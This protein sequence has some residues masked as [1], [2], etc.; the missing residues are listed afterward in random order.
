MHACSLFQPIQQKCRT[1]ARTIR[2]LTHLATAIGTYLALALTTEELTNVFTF[3]GLNAWTDDT[4]AVAARIK[5]ATD[6]FI[7][8]FSIVLK[9]EGTLRQA[10]SLAERHYIQ[11]IYSHGTGLQRHLLHRRGLSV[12]DGSPPQRPVGRMMT[13]LAW[14]LHHVRVFHW[15]Q[16]Q[17]SAYI[18]NVR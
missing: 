11:F 10:D 17:L 1:G 2:V 4:L 15:I 7:I 9:M 3:E 12:D 18:T 16:I 8:I 13:P 14:R 6:F 5:V